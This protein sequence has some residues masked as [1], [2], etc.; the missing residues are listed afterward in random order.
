MRSKPLLLLVVVALLISTGCQSSKVYTPHAVINHAWQTSPNTAGD[1][2]QSNKRTEQYTQQGVY[3]GYHTFQ[4]PDDQSVYRVEYL[5]DFDWSGEGKPNSDYWHPRHANLRLTASSLRYDKHLR[6][7]IQGPP[8]ALVINECYSLGPLLST[9]VNCLLLTDVETNV[10]QS[11]YSGKKAI[12]PLEVQLTGRGLVHT[13]G[14]GMPRDELA[15]STVNFTFG[16]VPYKEMSLTI[17]DGQD[18]FDHSYQRR[19]E[20]W[21]LQPDG[22]VKTQEMES[23]SDARKRLGIPD[24]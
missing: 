20:T 24:P 22:W 16:Q 14:Y 10:K 6:L 17:S 19:H 21:F 7:W 1:Q 9:R 5:A 11:S 8:I 12:L 3:L 23:P 13:N 15:D 2:R 4:D 18:P